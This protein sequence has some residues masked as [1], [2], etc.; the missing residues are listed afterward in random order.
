MKRLP[1]M[2]SLMAALV[3]VLALTA[4]YG[5][6]ACTEILTGDGTFDGEW[7]SACQSDQRTGRYTRYY[8]FN[9][10]EDADE[11]TITLTRTSG[12]A[13]TYLYLWRNSTLSGRPV[14]ENDDLNEGDYSVSEI[15]TALTDSPDRGRLHH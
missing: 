8:A 3:A 12:D 14:A 13:D 6:S 10:A 7:T 15:Q 4:V 1:I 11:V 9:L 5:Q 2:V